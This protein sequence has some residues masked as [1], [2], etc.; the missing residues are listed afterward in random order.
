MALKASADMVKMVALIT[1]ILLMLV[2][3]LCMCSNDYNFASKSARN[4][5]H[6]N[7]TLKK[8]KIKQFFFKVMC[9]PMYREGE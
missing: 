1:V 8:T 7:I 9:R 3:G 6:T 4:V 5:S 2:F